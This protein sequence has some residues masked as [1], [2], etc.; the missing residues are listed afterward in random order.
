LLNIR[1]GNIFI[2]NLDEAINNKALHDTFSAFGDILS[3]KVAYKLHI[4]KLK[5]TINQM[6]LSV[7]FPFNPH[8]P[9]G[10]AV[11]GGDLEEGSG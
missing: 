9:T 5:E 4:N 7:L 10:Q 3:C 11:E 8:N 6:G 1:Q 2:K